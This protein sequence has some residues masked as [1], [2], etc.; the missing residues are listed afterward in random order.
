M[1]YYEEAEKMQPE[2]V[3][4]RRD[5][6]QYPETAWT[7]FRTTSIIATVLKRLGF[8]VLL[9]KDILDEPSRMLVPDEKT[10][11]ACK[12]RAL[13]EGADPKL[14]EKMDGGHTGCVGVMHFSRPGKTVG[15]R[16]DIDS[17]FV[18]ESEDPDHRPTAEGFAS[19]HP[20]L[21]HACGHDG[22]ITIGLAV[23]RL[24][25]LHKER[26][27]GTL[28]I[29]FQPGEE[30]VV[31]AKAMVNSGLADDVDYF[32][33]GHI[34]LGG[35]EDQSLVIMAQ[36]FLAT[37]KIDAVFTGVPAHAGAEPEKGKNAL[38]AAAQAALALHTIPRHS[39]GAS[40][41]NVGVM[42]S[43]TGRNVVPENAV[44]KFETRGETAE[45]NNFVAENAWRMVE[46]AAEMY[47]VDVKMIPV[48]SATTV[49]SSEA[50]GK[51]I[52]QVLEPLH[53]YKKLVLEKKISGS[54]DCCYFL[55]R[56]QERGGQAVYMLYGTQEAAGHHQSRFDF[57]EAVLS[58]SA[59]TVATLVEH[60]SNK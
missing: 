37:D 29:F 41:I 24:V 59:A 26:M 53:Q 39:S 13:A 54:E 51:E 12:K 52:Y 8:E 23:A 16:F 36:G 33:S 9:G 10:L 35:Y 7:E 28:K 22:H 57:N 14:V 40:R 30:G 5:F 47:G 1:G 49:L 3:K 20:G 11:E 46:G 38:L 17:L 25:S 32:I 18:K 27:A 4:L 48:G 15:L 19:R 44:L 60:F 56:V 34:G 42:E 50:M 31:G 58:R 6:H 2:L 43:G 45:I 55:S 21:M